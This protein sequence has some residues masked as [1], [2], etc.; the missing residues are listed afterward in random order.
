MVLCGGVPW[1]A[2]HATKWLRVVEIFSLAQD[3][4]RRISCPMP[5][6]VTA[7]RMLPGVAPTG[8][9]VSVPFVVVVDFEGTKVSALKLQTCVQDGHMECW[10]SLY[11]MLGPV[12]CGLLAH[13]AS[14]H[15]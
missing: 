7:H 3:A 9:R 13:L 11:K 12:L 5:A 6:M 1:R 8:K 4:L 14:T 15:V 2:Y 10:A